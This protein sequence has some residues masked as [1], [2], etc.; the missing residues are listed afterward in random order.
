MKATSRAR[1]DFP[2][3]NAGPLERQNSSSIQFISAQASASL[4]RLTFT[5]HFGNSAGMSLGSGIEHRQLRCKVWQFAHW[6]TSRVRKLN[7]VLNSQAAIGLPRG[8]QGRTDA[9]GGRR[10][11]G[12]LVARSPVPYGAADP[13]ALLGRRTDEIEA[14]LGY[15]GAVNHW[16]DP[17]CSG[18]PNRAAISA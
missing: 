18:A 12:T 15:R 16:D 14:I 17:C 13:K 8:P 5:T 6:T 3:R 7:N 9:R 11:D 2:K 1:H 10:R 4:L